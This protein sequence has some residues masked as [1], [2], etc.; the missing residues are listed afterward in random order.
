MT[1]QK[2]A[3]ADWSSITKLVLVIL[4]ILLGMALF[5]YLFKLKGRLVP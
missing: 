2:K 1:I 4:V 3:E 5:V